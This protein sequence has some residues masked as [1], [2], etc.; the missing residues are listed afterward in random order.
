MAKE[1]VNGKFACSVCEKEYASAIHADACRDAHD[2]LYIPMSKDQLNRLINAIYANN[3]E[4]VPPSLIRTL[5]K[6]AR[7][8]VITEVRTK[9]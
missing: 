7:N 2:L 6:F 9:R 3:M 8:V 1:K 5:Q 4:I